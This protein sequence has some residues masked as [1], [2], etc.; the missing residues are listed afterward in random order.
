MNVSRSILRALA[1]R[2]L[3]QRRFK[4]PADHGF[5]AE[6]AQQVGIQGSVQTVADQARA[7]FSCFTCSIT[8]IAS[9]VAV[10]IGR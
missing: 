3:H 8:G 9:R 6:P 2:E 5:D 7:G 1:V 10:C 4:L